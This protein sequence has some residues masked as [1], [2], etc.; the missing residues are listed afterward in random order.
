MLRTDGS[1]LL[2]T[3]ASG[4]EEHAIIKRPVQ[5]G[6]NFQINFS[7]LSADLYWFHIGSLVDSNACLFIFT[8]IFIKRIVGDRDVFATS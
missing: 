6:K 4:S 5:R 8:V 3:T 1:R 2:S 7:T